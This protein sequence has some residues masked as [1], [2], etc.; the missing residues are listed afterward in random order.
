MTMLYLKIDTG[1][2]C[3]FDDCITVFSATITKQQRFFIVTLAN[4][5]KKLNALNSLF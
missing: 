4:G 2:L 3:D 1:D 5:C